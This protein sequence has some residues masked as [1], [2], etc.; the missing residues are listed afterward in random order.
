MRLA[1]SLFAVLALFPASLSA[2]TSCSPQLASPP[3]I[4]RG[5]LV[6]SINPVLP[7][8]QYVDERGE[9]QG[10]NAELGREIAKRLCLEPVYIRIDFQAMV[11]GLQSKRWDLINTGI[12]WTEERSRIM[13]LVNYG[14]QAVSVLTEA[15]NPKKIKVPEDLAGKAVAVEIGTYAERR[16]KQYSDEFAAKGLK[17]VDIRGFNTGAEGYQALRSGQ[18]DASMSIDTTA[19][20]LVKRTTFEWVMKGIG[21]APIAFA[22]ADKA[23]AEAVAGALQA[24]KADGTYAA[25]F[26]KFGFAELPEPRF[27]INGP[28]PT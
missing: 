24:L 25:L 2:Q 14:S 12:F 18:V 8:M 21:G 7:P 27:Q 1:A 20:D 19:A 22:A 3:L 9:L 10:L 26:G 16:L 6:M 5:K 13:Y 17:A 23:T 4:E 11:P 15:G 28:G